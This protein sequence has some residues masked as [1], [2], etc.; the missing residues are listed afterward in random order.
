M[1]E[2]IKPTWPPLRCTR[3]GGSLYVELVD[4]GSNWQPYSVV[5]C[6]SCEKCGAEWDKYGDPK[7]TIW[8]ADLEQEDTKR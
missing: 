1:S 2:K 3:C 6:I 4:E 7:A 8:L 5:D